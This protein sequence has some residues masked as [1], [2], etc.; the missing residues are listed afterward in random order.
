MAVAGDSRAWS[1]RVALGHVLLS[2]GDEEGATR[3]YEEAL[4]IRDDLPEAWLNL[5][6]LKSRAGEWGAAET[7]LARARQTAL[8]AQRPEVAAAAT[9]ELSAVLQ[10]A[11]LAAL[12]AE[13][14][15]TAVEKFQRACQLDPS[16]AA[17]HFH[18]GRAH[19]ANGDPAAAR[20]TLTHALGLVPKDSEA[21]RDI[22]AVLKEAGEDR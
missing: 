12:D 10:A 7:L 20:N 8:A 9:K 5:G 6:L 1:P 13:S 19:L 22:R 2:E 15:R 16:S 3:L 17:A 11:G 4:D 21:A 14:A 18:L